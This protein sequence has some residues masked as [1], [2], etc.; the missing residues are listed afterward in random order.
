MTAEGL[1]GSGQGQM[2]SHGDNASEWPGEK[3]LSAL[4]LFLGLPALLPP[5]ADILPVWGRRHARRRPGL[6]GFLKGVYYHTKVHPQ[7]TADILVCS[8]NR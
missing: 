8:A 2:F 3:E 7:A 5:H 4:D 6:C 1:K